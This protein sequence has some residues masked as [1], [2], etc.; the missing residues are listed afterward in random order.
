MISQNVIMKKITSVIMVVA[1]V[2]AV[3][4]AAITING[5]DSVY[6]E[7][8][9]S[10][11]SF[12]VGNSHIQSSAGQSGNFKGESLDSGNHKGLEP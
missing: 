10:G 6:A 12:N 2:I 3:G 8:G 11:S 1:I 5:Y 9:T 4:A 7:S